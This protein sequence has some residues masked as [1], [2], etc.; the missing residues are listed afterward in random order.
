MSASAPDPGSEGREAS[1]V[2]RPRAV[3]VAA[4]VS[5]AIVMAGM[6]GGAVMITSFH[7]GGSIGLLMVGVLVALFCHLEASVT[8]T[9]RPDA[10]EVRNLMRTRSLEWPEVLGISF[11]MGDP[12]AHLDLADGT[13]H[14]LHA[15]QRYDGQRA[16]AAAHQLQALIRERGEAHL[17]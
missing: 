16:I 2:I 1:I 12:W 9:A 7:W 4:Y 11:P 15:L 14:P 17:D 10:L 3:R 13:T 5:A 6:I 8:V